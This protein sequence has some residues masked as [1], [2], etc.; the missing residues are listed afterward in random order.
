MWTSFSSFDLFS[1]W[2]LS[3]VKIKRGFNIFM[4]NWNI[5][6]KVINCHLVPL[7]TSPTFEIS[8][9]NGRVM[10]NFE[11]LAEWKFLLRY[12]II[13]LNQRMQASWWYLL[14]LAWG[15]FPALRS[16]SVASEP[17]AEQCLHLHPPLLDPPHC[18]PGVPQWR[19]DLEILPE[20][21]GSVVDC[22]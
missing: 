3:I 8:F 6:A 11:S 20:E 19:C 13:E 15:C 2:P 1:N 18:S 22:S 21:V 17:G 10:K 12:I 16:H 9:Y 7:W 14:S 4:E 5:N